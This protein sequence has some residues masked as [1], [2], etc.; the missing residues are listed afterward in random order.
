[1][2][3]RY[4]FGELCSPPTK[5]PEG[6][7]MAQGLATR[8]GVFRYRDPITKKIVREYRPP[9]EVARADSLSTL[10]GKPLTVGHPKEPV[11]P[12]NWGEYAVGSVG[13]DVYV[14]SDGYVRVTISAQRA[15]AI[16]ALEGG[17][18]ELS[19][20]YVCE[21]DPTPG[22]TPDGEAYDAIQR[23]VRYDHLAIVQRGRAGAACRVRMDEADEAYAVRADESDPINTPNPAGTP[24][25]TTKEASMAVFKIDGA[26]HEVEDASLAVAIKTLMARADASEAL[27]AKLDATKEDVEKLQAKLDAAP[28][29]TEAAKRLISLRENARKVAGAREKALKLD[30]S[31]RELMESALGGDFADKSDVYVQVRFDHA[32]EQAE[33]RK[34]AATSLRTKADSA[35]KAPEAKTAADLRNKFFAD[36]AL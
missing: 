31:E 17:K 22:T 35:P 29:V 11:T 12:T 14:S 2:P 34:T 28:D 25:S 18:I 32:L 5:T 9:S 20:G 15:D 33:A 36:R 7:L 16:D 21:V 26:D 1:M 10:A 13:S 19:C 6:Y 3:I 24:A 8:T 30:G 27:Q 4:D 23:N